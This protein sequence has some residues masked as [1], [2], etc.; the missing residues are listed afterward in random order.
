MA[1]ATPLLFLLS[2]P[3]SSTSS[4]SSSSSS[5]AAG[6]KELLAYDLAT[7]RKTQGREF[8]KDDQ[9]KCPKKIPFFTRHNANQALGRIALKVHEK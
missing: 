9:F 3:T 4:S 2:E 5:A 1:N 7:G 6:N 8:G